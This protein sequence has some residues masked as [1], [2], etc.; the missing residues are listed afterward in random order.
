MKCPDFA[1]F[2]A[3][4]RNKN[5]DASYSCNQPGLLIILRFLNLYPLHLFNF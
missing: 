1:V 2:Y 3:D 5:Q 4:S